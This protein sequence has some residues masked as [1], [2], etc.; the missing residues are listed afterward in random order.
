MN[1][2]MIAAAAVAVALG[3]CKSNCCK[4]PACSSCGPPPVTLY[5]PPPTTANASPEV[6]LPAPPSNA[7]AV[8]PAP[9]APTPQFPATPQTSYSPTNPSRIANVPSEILLEKPEFSETSRR[10]VTSLKTVSGSADSKDKPIA[11]LEIAPGRLATGP[12]PTLDELDRLARSG[13]RRA[14][15][16]GPNANVSDNDKR[17]FATRG[18]TIQAAP[19]RIKTDEPAYVFADDTKQLRE[20]WIRHIKDS[21][22]VSD[23]A[24]RIRADR[25]FQ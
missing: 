16:V 17:V 11:F 15:V 20:W 13:Y 22:F 4:K 21:E 23:E 25:L 10:E 14:Y 6:W 19:A 8:P 9:A 1:R 12:R 5:S 2:S 7:A 24:A 3:G 18:L